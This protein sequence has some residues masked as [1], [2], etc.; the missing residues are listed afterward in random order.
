MVVGRG[1]WAVVR[2]ALSTRSS[3]I[4]CQLWVVGSGWCVVGCGS[5]PSRGRGLWVVVRVSWVV[6]RWTWW[7]W[8]VGPGSCGT[9]SLVLGRGSWVVV[10]CRSSFV[11]EVVG[12]WSSV[13]GR[14]S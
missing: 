3:V 8:V 12:R 10:G 4:G 14:G 6:G 11:N 13:V 7:S 1:S 9:G 5:G 2:R